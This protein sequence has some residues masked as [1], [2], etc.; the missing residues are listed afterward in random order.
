MNFEYSVHIPCIPKHIVAV[1]YHPRETLNILERQQQTQHVI[2]RD[3]NSIVFLTTIN[4]SKNQDVYNLKAKIVVVAN[5][6]EF[7]ICTL[8]HF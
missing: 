6:G 7:P 5:S 2:S 1:S 8:Y 3:K 4:N